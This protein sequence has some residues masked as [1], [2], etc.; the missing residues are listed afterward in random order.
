MTEK[1]TAAQWAEIEGGH[2]MT[3]AKEEPYSFLKEIHESRMTKDNGNAKKLTYTDCGERM[4]LTLLA[5]ETMRQYKDFR[6]YV[7]RY[8]KKT[9]GFELYKTYRIMGT[10]LYNFVYFLV[11]DSGAQDKLKDPESAKQLRA[12]TKLPTA[13]INRYINAVAQGKEP[14][15]INSMFM[16]IEGAIN[17]TNTDYKAIRRNLANFNKLTRAEKRLISTR[18]IFAVRAKLRSS[19]IIEDFEK[20]AAVKDL[21]KASVNDPEPTVSTPDIATRPS[22]LALYRYL[23]GD[24]N[25]ALTKKFLEA[26]K[27]GKA[28]SANM[29][30]AYLPAIEMIDDIV[31]AGPAYVQQL[32]A[33]HSRAKKR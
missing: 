27:D 1:Y 10:D 26:A 4:Y 31:Q 19:D 9:S 20:F 16:A 17:V 8:C 5:L 30:Q 28:A 33:V 7:Q 21:E 13:A 32:R 14:V 6:G 2:E 22:D 23:V 15:Q 29:V 18:L 11:G 3:P 24:K 12:K 25:L